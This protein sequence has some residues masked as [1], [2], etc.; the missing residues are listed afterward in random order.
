MCG[1]GGIIGKSSKNYAHKL[2]E[3]LQH[4]GPDSNNYWISNSNE[5][6]ATIC[7]T[8]LSILDL[9]KLG[10]QPFFYANKRYVFIFNGEIYNYIE[11]KNDL[12]KKGL[13]FK[14]KTDTEVFFRGLIEEGIDFQLKCNGMW[15]FA[16]W[17]RKSRKLILGR[18]RFGVK[19]LYYALIDNNSLIFG[20]EM[21]V[22]TPFLNSINPSK[23]IDSLFK[24]LFNYEISEECV[25]NGI[26]RLKPGH[27]L[28]Y[29]NS[30]VTLKRYWNTLDYISPTNL[31]YTEQIEKC[32]YLVGR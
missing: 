26:K 14:T 7:H 2:I 28:E 29:V 21:K 20:S 31:P 4:R 19:P 10:S 11:L 23:N 5:H 25:I 24:N 3:K 15:S 12:Q 17:D 6:P 8:R 18:D 30:E 32:K 27:I 9:S 22:I 13:K 1:I 16:L